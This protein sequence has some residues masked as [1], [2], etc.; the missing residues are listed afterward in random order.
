M[1]CNRLLD[2][3][4]ENEPDDIEN[5]EQ[6]F[7]LSISAHVQHCQSCR[8]VLKVRCEINHAITE[9]SPV[10]T[11]EILASLISANIQTT[12]EIEKENDS[13]PESIFDRLLKPLEYGFATAGIALIFFAGFSGSRDGISTDF[14]KSKALMAKS[15][16]S[17]SN[18]SKHPVLKE[19][20]SDSLLTE[21]SELV[22]LTTQ[23]ISDFRKK[24]D[25]FNRMHPEAQ[26]NSRKKIEGA[27]VRFSR[28]NQ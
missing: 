3:L 24:L 12:E 7:D 17:S 4:E 26:Q 5:I 25:F 27:V 11:P 2:W 15:I 16:S 18:S 23:E 6:C 19:K 21:S 20:V 1:K 8:E 28:S 9:I 13:I 14:H 10:D 22:T